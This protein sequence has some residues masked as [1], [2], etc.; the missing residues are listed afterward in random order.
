[1]QLHVPDPDYTGS[2]RAIRSF[3]LAIRLM[4]SALLAIWLVFGL[5]ALLPFDLT[6]FGLRPREV[7][8]LLGLVTTPFLHGNL[9]HLLSNSLPLFIGGV[10]MLFLYPTAALPALPVILIGSSALAWLFA[11]SSVHI[12]ASGV[13]YGILAFVFVSGMLRRDLRSVGVSMMIW[14]LYGSMIWGV[15]P[16]GQGTSWELHLS[17]AAIGL[18]MAFLLKSLDRPPIKRYDWEDDD[19]EIE[20]GPDGQRT[21]EQP[22][23]EWR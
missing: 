15:L 17:G 9:N 8:G 1:M 18:I 21:P 11:R 4:L 3:W 7:L 5:D 6:Q 10:A 22:W 13:V 20:V 2:P 14:L 16:S 12:G 19:E 23:R